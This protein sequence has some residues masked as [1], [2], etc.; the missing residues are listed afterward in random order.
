M[1]LSC[2]S[3][4][5]PWSRRLGLASI[6]VLV[7]LVACSGSQE[8][9]FVESEADTP[10]GSPPA[11]ARD[12]PLHL[13]P[14]A[15]MPAVELDDVD[16]ILGGTPDREAADEVRR[17]LEGLGDVS[18]TSILVLPFTGGEPGGLLV[19]GFE[20]STGLPS[21]LTGM[22]QGLSS[23]DTAGS[24]ISQVSVYY[25]AR[26]GEGPYVLTVSLSMAAVGRLGRGEI[27]SEQAVNEMLV[28]LTRS[29]P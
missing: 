17:R 15:V 9:R 1:P 20:E 10:A 5:K 24:G 6:L 28:Q 27:S 11:A 18:A 12:I 21:D 29:G 16:A 2:R 3:L 7:A 23:L 14:K 13:P 25:R 26:D 19:L 22:L 4:G 8:K